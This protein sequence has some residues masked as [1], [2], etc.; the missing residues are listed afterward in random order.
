MNRSAVIRWLIGL[1]IYLVALIAAV[2]LA[3]QLRPMVNR[4]QGQVG[5]LDQLF[6]QL[7]DDTNKEGQLAAAE[8]ILAKGPDAVAAALDH[9]Y[10]FG[11]AEETNLG[12]TRGGL[13][14][15]RVGPDAVDA[16]VKAI[17]SQRSNVRAARRWC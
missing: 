16:L 3:Q 10:V 13:A 15:P 11:D 9:C 2:L 6:S 12:H 1:N 8:K 14:F 17:G 7:D 5:G 4:N